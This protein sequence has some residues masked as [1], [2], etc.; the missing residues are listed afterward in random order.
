MADS[1]SNDYSN[2]N[3]QRLLA[4]GGLHVFE[5]QTPCKLVRV[6]PEGAVEDLKW[7]ETLAL[8][9]VGEGHAE[10]LCGDERIMLMIVA[11]ARLEIRLVNEEKPTDVPVQERFGVQAVLYDPQGRELEVGKFTH[12]E[13]TSSEVLEVAN[14]PSAAEFGF[15]DTCFGLHNFLAVRP[16]QALIIARLRNLE[17]KL[18][19]EAKPRE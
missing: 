7:A 2:R 19:I 11:P 18:M 5:S 3:G 8:E 4:V 13:W 9:A 14:D 17:G 12:F 1:L 6:E 10:V 16:G 15:C